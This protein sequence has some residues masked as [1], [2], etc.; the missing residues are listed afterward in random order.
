NYTPPP[1]FRSSPLSPPPTFSRPLFHA[2]TPIS[3]TSPTS[4]EATVAP[5]T[6]SPGL[7]PLSAP[8]L[9]AYEVPLALSETGARPLAQLHDSF[10]LASDREGM[11]IVDQHVAHERVLY[12]KILD[13]LASAAPAAQPL[14]TPLTFDLTPAQKLTLARIRPDLQQQGFAVEDFG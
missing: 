2:T 11:L 8:T 4:G 7:G 1:S 9:A 6:E 10:I 14:L 3:P 12:E 13:Q 5:L